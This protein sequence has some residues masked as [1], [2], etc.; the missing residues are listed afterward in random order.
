MGQINKASKKPRIWRAAVQA[1]HGFLEIALVWLC[2]KT[3]GAS[4]AT[5]VN[6]FFFFLSL[7]CLREIPS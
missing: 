2:L 5:S 4:C 7:L 6:F 1:R 3:S